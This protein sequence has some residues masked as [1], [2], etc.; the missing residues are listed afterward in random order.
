MLYHFDAGILASPIMIDMNLDGVQDIIFVVSNT[1][2][3]LDGMKYELIWN[4]SLHN[5]VS[6]TY[7]I[8][9]TR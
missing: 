5:Y 1:V 2:F 4:I 6:Y 3:V 9:V 7:Q 8:T